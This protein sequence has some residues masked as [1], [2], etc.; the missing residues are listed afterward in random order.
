[1]D[2]Y[3]REISNINT[4]SRGIARQEF[5]S[6]FYKKLNTEQIEMATSMKE[7]IKNHLE[8]VAK[9]NA[10]GELL[11]RRCNG[12][13]PQSHKMVYY[14]P[15]TPE[16][17]WGPCCSDVCICYTKICCGCNKDFFV[18][19]KIEGTDINEIEHY[20]NGE[21]LCKACSAHIKLCNKCGKK[22]TLVTAPD[23]K[24]LCSSCFSSEYFT[25]SICNGIHKKNKLASAVYEPSYLAGYHHILDMGSKYCKS[26]YDKETKGKARKPIS[27][28]ACCSNMFQGADEKYC[29]TCKKNGNVITCDGCGNLHHNWEGFRNKRFCRNCVP[30]ITQC[31]LCSEYNVR[32]KMKTL[33]FNGVSYQACAHHSPEDFSICKI[34]HN[35]YTGSH[36]SSCH[37]R[38][39][40]CNTCGLPMFEERYCRK[41]SPD[42]ERVYNY[43]YKPLTYFNGDGRVYFGFENEI[44]YSTDSNSRI[45]LKS[46]FNNYKSSEI[47]VKSD[48]TI[49]QYG[50]EVVS[51]PMTMDYFNS[52]D[53]SS[54]FAVV[55]KMSDASCGLHVHVSRKAFDGKV[56]LYKFIKLFN[57]NKE[58]IKRVG[59]RSYN[60]YARQYSN[61]ISEAVGKKKNLNRYSVVNITPNKTVEIRVFRGAKS[62]Y[63]LRTRIEFANAAVEYTRGCGIKETT[64]EQFTKW[65]KGQVG[66]VNL[67]KFV[68]G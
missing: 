62:E 53:L 21:W 31:E 9:R 39:N 30:N 27:I 18:N 5:F 49:S 61:K 51:Q 1:M 7:R 60:D 4:W 3:F 58:F 57:D 25:C 32:S 34:C 65:L 12:V 50:F 41:C 26:C 43:G 19:K 6:P 56:H 63:E 35:I 15:E 68:L 59:G 14:N 29:P 44:N 46:I 66:Y 38:L 11:C 33:K 54:L 36:C 55:P 42:N 48:S 28:C 22:T 47:Y 37:D 40:R 23:G 2:Y 17:I 8:T 24:E 67:K 13:V 45:Q 16:H 52:M 10:Q 20:G 64:D